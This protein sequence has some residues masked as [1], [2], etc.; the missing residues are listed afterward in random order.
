MGIDTVGERDHESYYLLM[1]HHGERGVVGLRRAEV[2]MLKGTWIRF[3]AAY[4]FPCSF[5]GGL[6]HHLRN[7]LHHRS[8]NIHFDIDMDF[9]QFHSKS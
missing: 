5:K 2:K 4:I 9:R 3:T 8:L 6:L 1:H 7:V